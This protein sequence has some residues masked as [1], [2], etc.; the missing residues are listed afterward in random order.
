MYGFDENS[1]KY[2]IEK[3][4][5]K[6][7]TRSELDSKVDKVDG[8][9]LSTNN[10]SNAYKN[11]L[12]NAFDDV[13]SSKLDNEITLS[14]YSNDILKKQIK[15]ECNMG[16]GS[17]L[18][19]QNDKDAIYPPEE[20]ISV[21]GLWASINPDA[22]GILYFKVKNPEGEIIANN[23][24]ELTEQGDIENIYLFTPIIEGVYN[25]EMY[26]IDSYGLESNTVNF[27]MECK[28]ESQYT[29]I[30][31]DIGS[32]SEGETY[33]LQLVSDE[34]QILED[35]FVD[36]GDGTTSNISAT[37]IMI[38]PEEYDVDPEDIEE[39]W[40]EDY[41]LYDE[42]GEFIGYD[43]DKYIEDHTVYEERYNAAKI[44][45]DGIM[46]LADPSTASHTYTEGGTYTIK[47][48]FTFGCT[49]PSESM[50]Y[51]LEKVKQ[52]SNLGTIELNNAFDSCTY[53]SSVNFKGA[54]TSNVTNMSYMFNLCN[55][56][57][58]HV[59]MSSCNLE[60]VVHA[61][62][63]FNQCRYLSTVN[64]G[65]WT[66]DKL[67]YMSSMFYLCKPLAIDTSKWTLRK[68]KDMSLGF[69]FL[70]EHVTDG[71]NMDLS[72]T[73]CEQVENIHQA[74][75][76]CGAKEL[77]LSNWNVSKCTVMMN[78]FS[79]CR[80]ATT[81]NISGWNTKQMTSMQAAFNLCNK[82][83]TLVGIENIDTSNVT[84][85]KQMF[86]QCTQ[87]TTL[88]LS[89]WDTGNVTNISHMFEYCNSLNSLNVSNFDTKNVTTM[90]YMFRD[91]SSLTSLDISNWN[92]SSVTDLEW[93]FQNCNKLTSL[94]LSNWNTNNTTNMKGVFKDCP[95]LAQLNLNFN[96]G[97]ATVMTQMFQNCS[98]LTS[99]NVSN[100]DTSNVTDMSY[101]F[102]AC[103]KLTTLDLSN[104]DTSNVT[105]MN[106]MFNGCSNL[107]SLNGV[108][109]LVKNNVTNL[110]AMF[111]CCTSLE[112]IDVSNWDTSSVTDMRQTFCE[113][114]SL[115]TITGIKNWNTSNVTSMYSMFGAISNMPLV[116]ENLDLTGWDVRKVTSFNNMFSYQTKLD[117]N[118]LSEW[119]WNP[120]ALEDMFQMFYMNTKITSFTAPVWSLP[121]LKYATSI[122]S[123]CSE[124]QSL[125]M[126][127][128][129][130]A[131]VIPVA[132]DSRV[133]I[134]SGSVNKIVNFVPPTNLSVSYSFDKM[135]ELSND[136]VA[137]IIQNLKT[138]S[139]YT[140]TLNE[141]KRTA[142][143]NG[144]TYNGI[145]YN[146][147][148]ITSKGWNISF[149]V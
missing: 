149:A 68:V 104:W 31:I 95:S 66:A 110:N 146:T 139:G 88:D 32:L 67:E 122:F 24:L 80:K 140:L 57:L 49:K 77:N 39:P 135:S 101:M 18:L 40:M 147:A 125:D 35:G 138:I 8:K 132:S 10:F 61:T 72:N 59:D 148:S 56:Y 136:S 29:I 114:K 50:R 51:A 64:F 2:L 16:S 54:D 124:L 19:I 129:N 128:W 103:S 17:I 115:T 87:L 127:N 41:P 20:D 44:A 36:W 76:C 45:R 144:F 27:D 60:N 91:C 9:V 71:F 120:L 28:N 123:N 5:T 22:T 137:R 75:C 6:F 82:L 74:F 70:G 3:L 4:K 21:S 11:K 33:T 112:T 65:N 13:K 121:N 38:T 93:M 14:F 69:Q 98:S 83:T 43:Y 7:V 108:E 113:C 118:K 117:I 99:L 79:S 42:N 85:M 15:Y 23:Q 34:R 109:D 141:N 73:C 126:S 53:L 84:N 119:N 130:F 97:S 37:S 62:S 55:P 89:N 133:S 30:E 12:S 96:T 142:I 143:A 46:M 86:N 78:T 92:T 1:L 116:L 94:D 58:T 26:I 105:N 107:T 106:Y 25:V 145:S 131:N 134:A 102:N 47:G 81:I 63:A 48:K 90:Q 111:H 100:F 52:F